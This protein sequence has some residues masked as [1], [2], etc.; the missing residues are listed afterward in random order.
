VL[1]LAAV[2]ALLGVLAAAFLFSGW[3]SGQSNHR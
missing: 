3:F 2:G 1:A